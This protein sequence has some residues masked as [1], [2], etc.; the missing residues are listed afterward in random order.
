[1]QAMVVDAEVVCD[2]V[3]DG[4]RHLVDDVVSVRRTPFNRRQ[5]IDVMRSGSTPE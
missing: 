4:D 5:A 2:L 3:H 1:V